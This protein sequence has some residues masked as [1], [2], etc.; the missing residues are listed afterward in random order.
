[1]YLYLYL[2]SVHLLVTIETAP[3][4]RP[5]ERGGG[6]RQ[7]G[8]FLVCCKSCDTEL[9]VRGGSQDQ[10]WDLEAEWPF[11]RE[12]EKG[13]SSQASR[14]VLALNRQKTKQ[15]ANTPLSPLHPS[16]SLLLHPSTP[17]PCPHT[18]PNTHPSINQP[19]NPKKV[20]IGWAQNEEILTTGNCSLECGD[21][22]GAIVPGNIYA[23][24]IYM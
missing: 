17:Q 14:L 11:R 21:R 7:N 12:R 13:Q 5:L 24:I 22:A 10:K 16:L 15:P 9:S 1:M 2:Y 6:F 18:L 19:A 3:G 8:Y 4:S 20:L 23:C